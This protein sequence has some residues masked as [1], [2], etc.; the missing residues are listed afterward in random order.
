ML[1]IAIVGNLLKHK[2]LA[3]SNH[4]N[5]CELDKGMASKSLVHNCIA[6][7]YDL[8]RGALIPIA[9]GYIGNAH[10]L[11]QEPTVRVRRDVCSKSSTANF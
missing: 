2:N 7:C 1:S 11:L 4:P 10:L 9:Y 3:L 8:W 6:Y 5:Y